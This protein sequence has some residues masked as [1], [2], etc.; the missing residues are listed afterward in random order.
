MMRTA[1]C[2]RKRLLALCCGVAVA[3]TACGPKV[4]LS[5]GKREAA[6]DVLYGPQGEKAPPPARPSVSDFSNTTAP[7]F[8]V[9]PVDFDRMT[10]RPHDDVTS[11]TTT[12][13]KPR[14]ACPPADP[15]EP[16]AEGAPNVVMTAPQPGMYSFRRTGF[17]RSAS[18]PEGVKSAPEVPLSAEVLREVKEVAFVSGAEGSVIRYQVVQTEP[19]IVT[20]TTYRIEPGVVSASGAA[21]G[22][23]FIEQ[24]VTERPDLPSTGP[25]GA[26]VF[27]AGRET[28]T[29]QPSVRIMD[30]PAVPQA[31]NPDRR[32][33]ALDPLT[34]ATIELIYNTQRREWVDVCGTW[35]DA[36][37]VNI[38]FPSSY[39][40]NQ[41]LGTSRAFHFE[42]SFWFAP[43][44]GGLIIRDS[45]RLGNETYQASSFEPGPRYFTQRSD[46]VMTSVAP[47]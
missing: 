10:P 14:P 38:N 2:G 25:S 30:L 35:V 26:P 17:V 28:F 13:L 24:I 45:M 31:P 16:P 19:G 4:P 42:G 46:A 43:Q 1:A 15:F 36:W 34:G 39:N 9:A 47:R 6:L 27:P 37:R 32:S 12:T 20:T 41:G 8:I 22:G 3:A 23:V 11:T 44:L 21:T 5:V 33:R 7:G 18:R 40:T 29:P